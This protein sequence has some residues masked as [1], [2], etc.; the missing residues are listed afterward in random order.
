MEVLASRSAAAGITARTAILTVPITIHT[1]ATATMA[2]PLAA[3]WS[4]A[5][6]VVDM[7][8]SSSIAGITGLAAIGLVAIETVAEIA[9]TIEATEAIAATKS[10]R[11]VKAD[12]PVVRKAGAFLTGLMLT[13]ARLD[14]PFSATHSATPM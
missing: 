3:W 1:T 8:G 5:V 4:V 11:A 13:N 9:A 6:G 2:A 10:S 7:A 12:A 14:A